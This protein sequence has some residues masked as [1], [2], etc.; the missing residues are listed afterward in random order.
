MDVFAP[1]MTFLPKM[2]RRFARTS[3]AAALIVAGCAAPER[4]DVLSAQSADATR[5]PEQRCEHAFALF[6]RVVA[7]AG[8]ADAE[9][10]R[11]TGF[12][13]LRVDRFLASFRQEQLADPAALT[14]VDAMQHLAADARRV[15]FANLP[16]ADKAAFGDRFA[17]LDECARYLREH[18]LATPDGWTKLRDAAQASDGYDDALRVA[19]LYP[20]TALPASLG[21][22]RYEAATRAAFEVPSAL[23]PVRGELRTYLPDR[24]DALT[25][26]EIAALFVRARNSADALGVPQLTGDDLRRLQATFAPTFIVDERS[27][28]DRIGEPALGPDGVPAVVPRAPIVFTR[29]AHTRLDDAVLLQ[30]IYTAWFP[31]RTAD[32]VFDVLAGPLDGIVWRVTFATDGTPL[33]FDSIHPCGCYH[34]F[35]PTARLAAKPQ[36]PSID[37]Q[38]LIAQQLPRVANDVQIALRVEASTH[39]LRRVIVDPVS[40]TGARRYVLR[41]EDTLR[42]LPVPGNGTRSLYGPDGIVHASDRPE[43]YW[44]WPL[45]I[46]SAGAMRQWGHHATA[47]VGRRDFD[48][49][50]L[51]ERYFALKAE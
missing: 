15:E 31:A 8:V 17:T 27:D 47:F 35:F 21:I 13:W 20:L 14:W 28:D 39:Y 33:L 5:T 24:A 49:P 22:R 19:G 1:K 2:R 10:A 45:G 16:A 11:V 42:T 38:A 36:P 3:F 7:E 50:L 26:S 25:A 30:L 41:A 44:F 51:V 12:P 34:W 37:E 48:E 29:L 6:D 43:R 4:V 23:L 18:A 9:A 32:S 46:P 40:A